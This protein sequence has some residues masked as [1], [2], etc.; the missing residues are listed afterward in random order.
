MI[1]EWFLAVSGT[2]VEWIAGLFPPID[3]PAWVFDP[4]GGLR[5]VLEGLAG[6]GY[7]IDYLAIGVILG[8]AVLVYV[9]T[10]TVKLVLRLVSHV[11]AFGGSG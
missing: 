5:P 8:V 1:A 7:W 4:L 6:A 9:T 10:F 11:P 3:L 2:F